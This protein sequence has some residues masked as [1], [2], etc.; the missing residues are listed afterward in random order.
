MS[1]NVQLANKGFGTYLVKCEENK[2][3]REREREK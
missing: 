2:E 1:E 3:E